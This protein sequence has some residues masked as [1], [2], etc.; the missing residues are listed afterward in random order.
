[1]NMSRISSMCIA[2][3]VF[4]MGIG[5]ATTIKPMPSDITLRDALIQ[6]RD[7]IQVLQEKAEN[8]KPA[9]LLISEVQ[10]TFNITANSK[11]TTKLATLPLPQFSKEVPTGNY[12]RYSEAGLKSKQSNHFQV[13]EPVPRRQRYADGSFSNPD[14]HNQREVIYEN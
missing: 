6:V 10:V 2:F 13:S 9:G 14:H 12:E 3:G 5:C 1:M 8:S 4:T 7:G 11:D